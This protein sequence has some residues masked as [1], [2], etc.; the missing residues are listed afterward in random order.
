MWKK[1]LAIAM[2]FSQEF[3]KKN[4]AAYASSIAFFLFLSLI[5]IA[6]VL[7]SILPFT[8]LS[9]SDLISTM[10]TVMP[11][12]MVPLLDIIISDV[13]ERSTGILSLA[14]LVAIWSAGKGMLAMIRGLN[15]INEVKER[16]NYFILRIE[17]SGYTL[18]MLSA[19]LVALILMVFGNTLLDVVLSYY[20]RLAQP[21][22]LIRNLRFLVSWGVLT[23]LF[24]V[25]YTYVPSI[26][27]KF[28]YQLPGATFSAVVWSVFSFFFSIYIKY[29]DGFSTYGSL[30]TIIIILLWMYFCFYIIMIGA[31]LNRYFAPAYQVIFFKNRKSKSKKSAPIEEMASSAR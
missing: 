21:L 13:Y 20:P 12:F 19:V 31:F 16:R 25:I 28:L 29:F 22:E 10:D 2:D 18:I 26:H 1:L 5:P 30:T 6:M 27:Q 3:N 4:I 8:V 11:E 14:I 17:A 24:A 23:L 7:V 15:E 9:E